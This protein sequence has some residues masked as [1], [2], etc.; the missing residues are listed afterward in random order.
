VATNDLA[1]LGWNADLSQAFVAHAE[2]GLVPG[3][4]SLEH[5]HVY[6]VL[7][8]DGEWLAE[9]AGRVKYEA[10]DRQELP[11]VGDWVAVRPDERHGRRL[12]RAILPRR[13]TL[14]RKVAGRTTREQVLAAN[15][16]TAFLVAG[17]DAPLKPRSLERYLA[18]ARQSGGN[19]V[20]VLNKAD[21][22]DA[23]AA[24]HSFAVALA[25]PTPVETVSAKTGEGLDR[26]R[27]WLR[28]GQTIVLLGPSGAGKSTL[29]NRL[30]GEEHL[31]TGDVRTWDARGRHTSVHRH[32]LVVPS[33]GVLI[34]TPGLRELALW[35]AREA[36]VDTF[37]DVA[38]L[39]LEC[40]FRDCRHD[41][42]PG[43]AVR[44]AV[45]Q[46][47][48]DATRLEGYLQL[49]RERATLADR[50]SELA[51]APEGHPRTDHPQTDTRSKR[52]P[53]RIGR[54]G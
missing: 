13:R 10:T 11:A 45:Q 47:A 27:E 25:G 5:N 34:D 46:G 19:A 44:L 36:V 52:R 22:C 12:I 33:G 18:L 32:L 41:R 29:I 38:A 49:E 43:C 7:T 9:T 17:L 16:D 48:F 53:R 15:V 28:F 2:K 39:A 42:E 37:A 8:A 26:L 4:V 6:R 51:R 24:A 31:A 23:L 1:N 54:G 35:D 14:S 21:A 40:R 50:Q 3:R 20:L 30:L